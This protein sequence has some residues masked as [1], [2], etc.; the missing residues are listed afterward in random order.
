M[1]ESI[2]EKIAK[3]ILQTIKR[4]GLSFKLDQLTEGKGDC[5]P[6]AIIA[7]CKRKEIYNNLPRN[8]QR[9]ISQNDPT[10]F[11]KALRD[12]ILKS[13]DEMIKNFRKNYDEVVAPVDKRSWIQFWEVMVRA[14]EWVDYTFVQS[15]AWFLKT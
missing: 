4:L 7:Q 9:I 15:T 11:R 6:L 3:E 2:E 10:I 5:F 1:E 14:Y 12:S 13:N 8:I